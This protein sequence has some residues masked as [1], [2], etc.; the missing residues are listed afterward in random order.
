[1]NT[2]AS[3]ILNAPIWRSTC[4]HKRTD[5]WPLPLK[6]V[7]SPQT[8]LASGPPCLS[9]ESPESYL[10]HA[11]QRLHVAAFALHD[12]AQDVPPDHLPG[13]ETQ[14]VPAPTV[15][16]SQ[17]LP[18]AQRQVTGQSSCPGAEGARPSQSPLLGPLGPLLPEP[19]PPQRNTRAPQTVTCRQGAWGLEP[20]AGRRSHTPRDEESPP[21]LQGEAAPSVFRQL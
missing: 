14:S 19:L 12:G 15:G 17:H 16:R 3:R 10:E 7:H 2:K 13:P 9:P 11:L 6:T 8:F 20:P 1:M 5:L 21:L 4:R 18:G